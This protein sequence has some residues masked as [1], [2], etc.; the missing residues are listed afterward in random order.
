MNF[1]QFLMCI[2]DV[3]Y[4]RKREIDKFTWIHNMKKGDYLNLP[5][6]PSQFE[7]NNPALKFLVWNFKLGFP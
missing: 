6:S 1:L 5:M 2:Y 3:G 4:L 7:I